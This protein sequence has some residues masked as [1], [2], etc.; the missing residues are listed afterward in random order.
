VI[1]LPWLPE[2]RP[3]FERLRRVFT[4]EAPPDR[5]PLFEIGVDSAVIRAFTG[6]T[7]PA[8]WAG[9]APDEWY[10]ACIEFYHRLGYDAIPVW[11]DTKF[12][13]SSRRAPNTARMAEGDRHWREEGVGLVDSWQA[14][15][16]YPWPEPADV[17]F[18]NTDYICAHLPDGMKAVGVVIGPMELNSSIMGTETFLTSMLEQPDLVDAVSER[19]GR[20][21]LAATENLVQR[22]QIGAIC[23]ADDCGFKTGCLASPEL[24]VRFVLR[25]HKAAAALCH[26]RGIPVLFHSCGNVADVM[27]YLIDEVGIAAKHSFEDVILPAAEAKRRYGKRI[28][29]LGGADVNALAYRPVPELR[30]Y[31]RSL[32][33]A[34]APGGGYAYGSGNSLTNYMPFENILAFYEELFRYN[35]G[36]A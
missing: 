28:G 34:C 18:S 36:E 19:V 23:L 30:R 33:E 7:A 26:A 35:A 8:S 9:P 22:E 27:D 5:V 24:L 10:D 16:R 31:L 32:L 25:Y 1:E 29:I 15:E 3:D 20:I 11:H 13:Y 4:R 17:D 2:P 14:F 12:T 21:M 6:C